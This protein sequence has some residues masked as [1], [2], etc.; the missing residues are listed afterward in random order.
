MEQSK[1][2][3]FISFDFEKFWGISDQG[4]NSRYIDENIKNVD[5]VLPSIL[6]ILN[7]F[8]INS[9]FAVV[10]ILFL[11]R[12]KLMS[13]KNIDLPYRNQKQ[14]PFRNFNLLLDLP[15]EVLF[16]GIALE[17]L[18]ESNNHEIASHTFTHF[19]CLEEGVEMRH[20]EQDLLR[21]NDIVKGIKSFV[22]PRNQFDEK[23]LKLL[24][25][26]GIRVV[27]VNNEDSYLY[28]TN[29][30]ASYFVRALRFIDRHINISGKNIS[31][32]KVVN[33]MYLQ[34][35]SRF[36]APYI[37]RL[38]WLESFKVRRIKNEMTYCAVNGFDYHLWTHPHNF[39]KNPKE[40]LLQLHEIASHYNCLNKKYGF[41]S[42]RMD[43]LVDNYE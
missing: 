35:H 10:G 37:A 7:S 24:Y 42:C 21:Y 6:D 3:F 43:Q 16:G 33:G 30:K 31:Q 38:N 20:F 39:G 29:P 23:Y 40:M 27:R 41:V 22:F 14:N 36:F 12:Q 4:Y 13:F 5:L 26:Y 2:R 17:K 28:K 32:V 8:K 34:T 25:D 19:Y 15:N 9:T 11:N 18:L 1:G